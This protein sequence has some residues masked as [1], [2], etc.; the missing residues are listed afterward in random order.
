MSD[1]IDREI[2]EILKRFDESGPGETTL[3]SK[4]N[5]RRAILSRLPHVSRRRIVFASLVLTALIA[6]GLFFGPI[7]PSFGGSESSGSETSGRT[8]MT[9]SAKGWM[10]T[11]DG[12]G[13]RARKGRTRRKANTE[14]TARTKSTTKITTR[15]VASSTN[16]TRLAQG[17]RWALSVVISRRF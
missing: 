6:A 16:I 12:S 13:N 10:W 17:T 2:D 5:L 15:A 14:R 1:K 7:H 11:T 4:A 3:S 9:R 8:L